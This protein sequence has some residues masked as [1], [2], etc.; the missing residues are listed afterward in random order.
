[1]LLKKV[2]TE[3]NPRKVRHPVNIWPQGSFSHTRSIVSRKN[4]AVERRPD[5]VLQVAMMTGEDKCLEREPTGVNLGSVFLN[6][7]IANCYGEGGKVINVVTSV[8][9]IVCF[10]VAYCF[11]KEHCCGKK[12]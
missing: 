9:Q 1:M 7:Y 2:N 10:T 4:I 12:A 5:T 3:V 8:P 11:Q 6:Q